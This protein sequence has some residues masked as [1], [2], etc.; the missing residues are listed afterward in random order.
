MMRGASSRRL[1]RL[2][3][4]V[5]RNPPFETRR[6]AR[7][8]ATFSARALRTLL[9]SKKRSRNRRARVDP[10][11]R[12]EPARACARAR[13]RALRFPG[14]RRRRRRACRRR[15]ETPRRRFDRRRRGRRGNGTGAR[16]GG[17]RGVGAEGLAA[18]QFAGV[19][20]AVR[21][22]QQV[23]AAGELQAMVAAERGDGDAQGRGVKLVARAVHVHLERGRH[24]VAVE[25]REQR[26]GGARDGRPGARARGTCEGRAE[27]SE[28]GG[29]RGKQTETER[30]RGAS[31]NAGGARTGERARDE[32]ER[33]TRTRLARPPHRRVGPTTDAAR[34][35]VAQ[36]EPISRKRVHD[37][38]R[39]QHPARKQF[40]RAGAGFE[41]PIRRPARCRA[42]S[43]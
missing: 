23:V 1:P 38:R 36:A 39:S 15:R 41:R 43:M 35:D 20:L 2:R 24:L 22:V 3:N 33:E 27:V 37:G 13:T 30:V 16:G 21:V 42:C 29:P 10:G 6:R 18:A 32:R 34:T 5:W 12:R 28:G 7:A 17:A 4:E 25:R 26:G 14:A 19:P 11:S 9:R 40:S 31:R 8:P